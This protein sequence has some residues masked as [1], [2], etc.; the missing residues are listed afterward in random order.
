MAYTKISVYTICKI[1]QFWKVISTIKMSVYLA[2]ATKKEM[3]WDRKQTIE[4]NADASGMY[5]YDVLETLMT[6]S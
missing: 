4:Y 5:M 3:Y 1:F 2:N 6:K